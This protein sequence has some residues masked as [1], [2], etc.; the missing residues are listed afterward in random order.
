M[1]L[2]AA[3]HKQVTPEEAL[4]LVGVMCYAKKQHPTTLSNGA[5]VQLLRRTELISSL[6][7]A[8]N[9]MAYKLVASTGYTSFCNIWL[10]LLE[11]VAM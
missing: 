9:K 7:H 11:L 8:Y 2:L 3:S 4:M 1:K 10:W 6:Q 5:L